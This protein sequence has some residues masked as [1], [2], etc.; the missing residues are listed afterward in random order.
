[1]DFLEPSALTARLH[2]RLSSSPG[3]IDIQDIL[4]T[5]ARLTKWAAHARL[6]ID[7]LLTRYSIDDGSA[8][9]NLTLVTEQPWM[10][11]LNTYLTDRNSFSST[12][13]N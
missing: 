11:N 3:V 10:L 12:A 8:P 9:G 2:R 4:K 13:N 5:Y 1:M 6:L 7:D